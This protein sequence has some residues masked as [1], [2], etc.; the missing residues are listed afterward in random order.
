MREGGGERERESEREREKEKEKERERELFGFS[1]PNTFPLSFLCGPTWR[2]LLEDRHGPVGGR[3]PNREPP[4]GVA[5]AEPA[6][7][8]DGLGP[9]EPRSEEGFDPGVGGRGRAADAGARGEAQAGVG[10]VLLGAEAVVGRERRE[11]FG[12]LLKKVTS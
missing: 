6:G 3:P 4:F 2:P 10:R 1:T 7:P 5:V 11:R 8:G 12:L 9:D